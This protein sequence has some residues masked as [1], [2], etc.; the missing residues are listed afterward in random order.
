MFE[1]RYLYGIY[2]ILDVR[3]S[4]ACV[5]EHHFYNDKK[6]HS[7]IILVVEGLCSPEGNELVFTFNS[8]KNI[9]P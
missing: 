2:L 7:S 4:C 9:N 8:Q 3:E 1:L 5:R 6:N